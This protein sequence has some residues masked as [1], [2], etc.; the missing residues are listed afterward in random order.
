MKNFSLIEKFENSFVQDVGTFNSIFKQTP[1]LGFSSDLQVEIKEILKGDE[2]RIVVGDQIIFHKII[3]TSPK[4]K[5]HRKNID[6]SILKK[7]SPVQK[8]QLPDI[9]LK[10]SPSEFMVHQAITLLGC[11]DG[12]EELSKQ[13]CLTGKTIYP[14]IKK[15]TDMGVVHT[16]KVSVDGKPLLRLHLTH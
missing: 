8:K 3:Q 9:F 1:I 16:E 14:I 12:I 11:I 6:I 5:A 13:I 2:R 10:L 15:L 4:S 7:V